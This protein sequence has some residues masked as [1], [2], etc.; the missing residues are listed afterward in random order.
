MIRGAVSQTSEVTVAQR[1]ATLGFFRVSLTTTAVDRSISL[2]RRNDNNETFSLSIDK[3]G[4]MSFS[5]LLLCT[6]ELRSVDKRRLELESESLNGW[7]RAMQTPKISLHYVWGSLAAFIIKFEG[8][9]ETSN[10]RIPPPPILLPSSQPFIQ[11]TCRKA[12][13]KDGA[14]KA[15][16]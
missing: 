5:T 7:I 8:I 16:K 6:R 11:R 15:S 10:L 13:F 1:S 2:P 3:S 12:L 9:L 14:R 4:A